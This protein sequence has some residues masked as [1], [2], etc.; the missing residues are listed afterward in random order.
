M[1]LGG[2]YVDVKGKT[3]KYKRDLARAKTMTEKASVAMQHRISSI[4]FR[5]V[6]I[7]ALAFGAIMG[8]ISKDGFMAVEK[9]KLSTASLASTITSFAKNAS[10]DLAGTYRQAYDYSAQLV[11]K[12]EEWNAKTVASGQ[13][14]MAMVETMAQGG[15]ILDLNNKNQEKGF[16]AIANALALVTQGQ[17]QDIQFRQETRALMTGQARM[18]DKLAIMLKQKVGGELKANVQLW[19]EQGTLIEN[20][21]ALLE[22]FQEGAKDLQRTWLAIG[23]TLETMYT[24]ILRGMFTPIY[25]DI[26]SMGQE[27]TLNIMNQNSGLNVMGDSL[28]GVIYKGWQDI[29][30]ITESIV[31]IIAAFKTPLLIVG[32]GISMILEG[33]GQIFAILP[34][35]TNRVKLLTQAIFDSIE[36]VVHLANTLWHLTTASFASA[37][38]PFATLGFAEASKSWKKTK[39]M[40]IEAGRKT[41]E[42]FSGGFVN[43]MTG[44][45]LAY[46]KDLT[47]KSDVSVVAPEMGNLKNFKAVTLKEYEK[48]NKPIKDLEEKHFQKLLALRY[49]FS[50]KTL[51]EVISLEQAKIDARIEFEDE[52]FEIGKTEEELQIASINRQAEIWEQMGYEKVAIAKWTEEQISE[53]TDTT[54]KDMKTAFAGWG[55]EFS[56]TLNEMLWGA[57]TTFGD[58]LKSFGKMITQ[59]LIQKSLIEPLFSGGSKG[60]LLSGL[61]TGASSLFSGGGVT[62][63]MEAGN[64]LPVM[65]NGGVFPG[66]ISGFSNG[67][68]NR[69]TR[70]NFAQ[71]AGLMG[72][73]GA[74]AIMPLTRTSDGDLGVKA[75]GGGGETTIIINAIDSK[76][77]AEVVKR[78][79]QSIVTVIDDA[80]K[81]RTG[82][83]DTMRS[84][85]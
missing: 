21:G 26:I 63:S 55:R 61:I 52:I 13:N 62:S 54:V 71:G 43:E 16:L 83:R 77:F 66:G 35:V 22:G 50:G 78:N 37:I 65:A 67:I 74:E 28:K 80:L 46:N 48:W 14:L 81:D 36:M 39:E 40:W 57:E 3:D 72:E 25:E 44:R 8:K 31:D 73:A 9:M 47:V 7:A 10:T 59:M 76:S 41:A 82:L 12:M 32:K 38:T 75:E 85:L 51:E 2:I 23:T 33:W 42:S 64:M 58:I 1:R 84:T 60:G 17:N 49:N 70:F 79:P 69:P 5:Q 4:S 27:I 29:K 11:L 19:K 20:V 34:A 53:I 18:T 15:V 45:L 24:R 30:N 68:V 6:G 56:G